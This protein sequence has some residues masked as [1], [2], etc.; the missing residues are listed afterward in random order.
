MSP[1]F[2]EPHIGNQSSYPCGTAPSIGDIQGSV[3][4]NMPRQTFLQYA[5]DFHMSPEH[6]RRALAAQCG[7]PQTNGE[8]VSSEAALPGNAYRPINHPLGG[9]ST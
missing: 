2:S 5:T 6:P 3:H 7:M 1:A 9:Y 4:G 8:C